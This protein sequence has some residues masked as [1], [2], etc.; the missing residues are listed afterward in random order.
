MEPVV[1]QR[2]VLFKKAVDGALC[3][4][5]ARCGDTGQDDQVRRKN[6][7]QMLQVLPFANACNR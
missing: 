4:L 2:Q 7:P 5:R 6:V 3:C 1:L